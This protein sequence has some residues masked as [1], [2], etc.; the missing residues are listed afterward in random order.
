MFQLSC[1][2]NFPPLISTHAAR[3][4]FCVL[5]TLHACQ[6]NFT[7]ILDTHTLVV[8]YL[9]LPLHVYDVPMSSVSVALSLILSNS[10]PSKLEHYLKL[11][12]M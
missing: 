9:L 6:T 8:F 10:H 2:D 11:D 12:V 4:K 5:N 3:F 7:S 1:S